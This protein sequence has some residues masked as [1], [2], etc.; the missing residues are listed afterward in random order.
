MPEEN[1]EKTEEEIE[2]EKKTA[3]S[4]YEDL[5][6]RKQG[7]EEEN[8]KLVDSITQMREERRTLDVRKPEPEAIEL[9]EDELSTQ[10]GWLKTIDKKSSD[11]IKP[12]VSELEKLKNTQRSKAF[13]S[14]IKNHPDYAALSDPNDVRLKELQATYDRI[15]TR[16]EYDADDITEDLE[17]AWA[18]LNRKSIV[19]RDQKS[20]KQKLDTEYEVS[21]IASSGGSYEKSVPDVDA[22]ASDR[23]IAQSIGMDLKKYMNLK[24]QAESLEV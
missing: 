2:Q 13:K 23:R 18:V 7:L 3:L 21:D 17:D 16:T 8:K 1:I 10:E 5:L 9:S 19:E 12:V 4:E 6:K 22:S 11:A 14:F 24:K 20:R 15:K